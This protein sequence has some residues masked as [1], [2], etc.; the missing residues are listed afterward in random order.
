[1]SGDSALAT[2]VD[3][4]G[5][6]VDLRNGLAANLHLEDPRSYMKGILS[7]QGLQAGLHVHHGDIKVQNFVHMFRENQS[8]A[9]ENPFW[10]LFDFSMDT[11][12]WMPPSSPIYDFSEMPNIDAVKGSAVAS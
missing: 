8:R 2:Q 10:L 11:N 1:M 7:N 3:F 4:P 12:T 9:N 6:P 5:L